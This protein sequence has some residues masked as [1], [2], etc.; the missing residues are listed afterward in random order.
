[1]DVGVECWNGCRLVGAGK[2]P[3]VVLEKDLGWDR[4]GW[5]WKGVGVVLEGSWEGG[6][7]RELRW[8]WKGP[9]VGWCWKGSG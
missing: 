1:M 5:C 2:G 3:V 7:G 9:E 8:C 4:V 6:A